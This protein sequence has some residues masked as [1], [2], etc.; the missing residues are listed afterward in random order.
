MTLATRLHQICPRKPAL[1]CSLS[2]T[3]KQVKLTSSSSPSLIRIDLLSDRCDTESVTA[4]RYARNRTISQGSGL[5]KDLQVLAYGEAVC[6]CSRL[7][8][9]LTFIFTVV[10]SGVC[11]VTTMANLDVWV[12]LHNPS[13]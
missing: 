10:P 1:A 7:D 13:S 2:R 9:S 5:G 8:V 3:G 12:A 11:P 4:Y 6:L